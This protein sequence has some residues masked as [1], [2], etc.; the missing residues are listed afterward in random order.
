MC[1]C[2]H[3][4]SCSRYV[5]AAASSS[6]PSCSADHVVFSIIPKCLQKINKAQ[7][8]LSLGTSEDRMSIISWLYA[9]NLM[10]KCSEVSSQCPDSLW[11][12]P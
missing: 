11:C 10:A 7:E 3:R 2:K 12:K 6:C 5:E 1:G 4:A 8:R 9:N